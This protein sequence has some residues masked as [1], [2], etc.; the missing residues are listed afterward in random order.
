MIIT[1]TVDTQDTYWTSYVHAPVELVDEL[2]LLPLQF[3]GALAAHK[4][5]IIDIR[6]HF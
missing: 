4:V 2:F 6:K 3:H 5:T 1:K